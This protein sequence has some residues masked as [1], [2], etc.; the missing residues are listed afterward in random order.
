[1]N[2]D[3]EMS[4]ET[5][6]ALGFFTYVREVEKLR[7]KTVSNVS[8]EKWTLCINEIQ[9]SRYIDSRFNPGSKL[10]GTDVLL[11]VYKKSYPAPPAYSDVLRGWELNDWS[12]FELRPEFISAKLIE[13]DVLDKE[14]N[15]INFEDS[16]QRV[17]EFNKWVSVWEDWSVECLE[18]KK[19]R[20]LFASLFRFKQDLMNSSE[21]VEMVVGN[22]VITSSGTSIQYPSL[23]KKVNI[24]FDEGLN[25]VSV[26][27]T[28]MPSYI[29][30]RP[31]G[32]LFKEYGIDTS[33][34]KEL[35][36]ENEDE[37]YLPY[38]GDET[39][40]YLKRFTNKLSYNT[41]FVDSPVFEDFQDENDVIHLNTRCCLILRKQQ[42]DL[43]KAID[44]IITC[45]EDTGY[46]PSHI[47][48]ILGSNDIEKIVYPHEPTREDR[49]AALGGEDLDVYLAKPANTEQLEIAKRIECHDAVLVQGPPGTGKTHTIAN[50]IGN[51]L[52]HG[53]TVLVTSEK[54]Q[55]LSV[56]K[57]KLPKD[58]QSLCVS[59]TDDS[60]E[61]MQKSVD[62]IAG[63]LGRFRLDKLKQIAD[64][65]DQARSEIAGKL[66]KERQLIYDAL[67]NE[68]RSIEYDGE[69]L[70]PVE[71]ARYVFEN[72]EME[73]IIP[74]EVV[75]EDSLPITMDELKELYGS[76][77]SISTVEEKQLASDISDITEIV[78]PFEFRSLTQNVTAFRN[79]LDDI[80]NSV[81]NF[82]TYD[83]EVPQYV[84]L[85][86]G[87]GFLKNI[88]LPSK[89]KYEELTRMIEDAAKV[90][91]K[92]I[93]CIAAGLDLEHT[94][95]KWVLFFESVY[96][97]KNAVDEFESKTLELD[98][99]VNQ[100]KN[101]AYDKEDILKLKEY[102]IEKGEIST[103]KKL[104]KSNLVK[105]QKSFTVNG[106]GLLSPQDCDVAILGLL[107]IESRKDASIV[108]DKI[109]AKMNFPKFFDLDE[110]YPEQIA[111]N[112]VNGFKYALYWYSE[113]VLPIK[114][115]MRRIRI[116][117]KYFIERDYSDTLEDLARK[118][119]K[120]VKCDLT[121]LFKF[122]GMV[123]EY[124]EYA[125][126]LN[127]NLNK[128]SLLQERNCQFSEIYKAALNK[129]VDIYEEEFNRL[130]AV[131]RKQSLA[132]SRN[133]TLSKISSFAPSWSDAI[134]DRKGIHGACEVPEGLD[135]AWKTKQFKLI[136]KELHNVSLSSAVDK[137][138]SLAKD[139]RNLTEK[140]ACDYGWYYL[141]KATEGNN[142]LHQALAGWS[143]AIKKMGKGTGKRAGIY[144]R[145]ARENMR[146][147][148][149]AVPVWIMPL[150][151][152]LEQFDPST[153]RF[154]VVIVD[155]ASQSDV[156]ALSVLYLGKK[157][158]IVGDDRQVSPL[159]I[160][161]NEDITN[162]LRNR[163]IKDIP[164]SGLIGPTYSLYDLAATTFHPLMLAEH[165]RC[166]P[167]IIGYSNEIY[168]NNKIKPLRSAS[169]LPLD[170]PMINLHVNGVREGTSKTNE[171]ESL[172]IASL[173][174][175]CIEDSRYK[176][177]SFGVITLLGDKQADLIQETIYQNISAAQIEK[178]KIVC[179]NAY[180]FQGDER[181]V[182]FLSM[183]DS[184]TGTVLNKRGEG[185]EE[186]IKKRYNVAV[187]R[188]KDQIWV[189]NSLD[190]RSDLKQGDMR[191][192]LLEY[193][194]TYKLRMG[195]N[196]SSIYEPMDEF[197]GLVASALSDKGFNVVT[198]WQI[199]NYIFDIVVVSGDNKVIV[200]CDGQKT[201]DV[202]SVIDKD[203]EA[204]LILQ[205]VGWNFVHIKASEYE[206]NPN[207][208]ID[209]L[210]E[211]MLQFN[212]IANGHD[213]DE[214]PDK[215]DGLLKRATRYYEQMLESTDF[216]GVDSTMQIIDDSID[217]HE[218]SADI[219]T[220]E[221][222]IDVA[223]FNENA[224]ESVLYDRDLY[225]GSDTS[226]DVSDSVE[227]ADS[228][229]LTSREVSN[230]DTA[231][232][233]DLPIGNQRSGSVLDKSNPTK[234]VYSNEADLETQDSNDVLQ[235]SNK[236][237]FVSDDGLRDAVG[238]KENAQV[239]EDTADDSEF[240]AA[241]DY[242]RARARRNAGIFYVS[243]NCP[244]MD[245]AVHVPNSDVELEPKSDKLKVD[246]SNISPEDLLPHMPIIVPN[247]MPSDLISAIK[248]IDREYIDLRGEKK[249]LW[250][251]AG[252]D[253][254]KGF[255]AECRKRGVFF[256]YEKDGCE[257]TGGRPA[258]CTKS[259]G[260][261]IRI[262]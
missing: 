53:K 184:S 57:D 222:D 189:V 122:M 120:L 87:E 242:S 24:T 58:M 241:T 149:Q 86:P 93:E 180:T 47:N 157:A 117:F 234:H 121:G 139:F 9:E 102:L 61:D 228:D 35:I 144:R 62:E 148:R 15:Y 111:V 245:K 28:D 5:D 49:L 195:R 260:F 185:R 248:A 261:N 254:M 6:K 217:G 76:N 70:L 39:S 110:E 223:G 212:V 116:D 136:L 14:N 91:D 2:V 81:N 159:G 130:D 232:N 25:A 249:G 204:Q 66:S 190:Y 50:L 246:I 21:S 161:L 145:Q 169:G 78:K 60:Q 257:A 258:W 109:T 230:L 67:E 26:V 174:K 64:R 63:N 48:R 194:S 37:C 215:E 12:S 99:D 44:S 188:A 92:F 143:Q 23:I 30:L 43:I 225:S 137:S 16:L 17:A 115:A 160:G 229:V 105:I 10:N 219:S 29:D 59:I 231:A 203:I 153:T 199:G 227:K 201:Y 253:E 177:K 107:V 238:F 97:A 142:S 140:C 51:F 206:L 209:A 175:A 123:Y 186:S 90:D 54:S 179:G 170:P 3:V 85:H 83:D 255:V 124:E 132:R 200:Q 156:G 237:Q 187:S 118:Y 176:N 103:F 128:L 34:I 129:K 216:I 74:G 13:S 210:I 72:Q 226:V 79:N 147:C 224:N 94:E 32:N 233:V 164:N 250:V 213:I 8:K 119:L 256:C 11:K 167:Q 205:R 135:I 4:I 96:G 218:Q 114:E 240:F 68:Y 168:Y 162:D 36:D 126:I 251:L 208:A 133:E 112:Y 33:S 244:L 163:Y 252:E 101:T 243:E 71:L 202:E 104:F 69:T 146:T 151:R 154:D 95:D 1:M 173:I 73:S 155:E 192:G 183:V 247:P 134:R 113:R 207:D 75:R 181:D 80:Q 31:F 82:W 55:A 165:F 191:R 211:K 41:K 38:G 198:N 259:I 65:E 127:D 178:H 197:S 89:D 19:A 56:L 100:F 262:D 7:L 98:V 77:D 108:W 150:Q 196:K 40:D 22:G 220:D 214:V 45:I 172:A 125:R 46:V 52:A 106:H 166:V 236:E 88:K 138:A 27:D 221:I 193:A 152:A 18:I 20:E 239:E 141:L 131:N 235:D 84:T 182:I 42:P 158:I 171:I